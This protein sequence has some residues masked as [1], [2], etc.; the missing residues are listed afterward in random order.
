MKKRKKTDFIKTS[1]PYIVLFIVAFVISFVY[2]FIIAR[3]GMDEVWCYGFAYNISKGLVPYRDFNMIITP[4][5]SFA[6]SL[7]IKIFTSVSLAVS[8]DISFKS[9][10]L[11]KSLS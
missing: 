8:L 6:G 2:E 5:Y 3:L 1:L 9:V 10:E 4:L 11:Y 7:F